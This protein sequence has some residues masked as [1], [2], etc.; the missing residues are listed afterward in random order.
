M[1]IPSP[2]WSPWWPLP[3]SSPGD[4]SGCSWGSYGNDS[5]SLSRQYGRLFTLPCG[6]APTLEICPPIW[7]GDWSCTEGLY[8]IALKK[9]KCMAIILRAQTQVTRY[10]TTRWS[11]C[12]YLS[13]SGNGFSGEPRRRGH[14]RLTSLKSISTT[15]LSSQ[16]HGWPLIASSTALPWLPLYL[17]QHP[18]VL[19]NF[20]SWRQH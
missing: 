14:M 15:L 9:E 20:P 18:P 19:R 5:R 2:S 17:L 6:F 4:T 16:S 12:P 10:S 1:K 7:M 13:R 11:K 3:D 8:R